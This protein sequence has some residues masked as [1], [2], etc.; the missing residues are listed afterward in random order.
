MVHNPTKVY[1]LSAIHRRDHVR[2]KEGKERFCNKRREDE[3]KKRQEI[4]VEGGS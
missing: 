2:R 3:S 1:L 4:R